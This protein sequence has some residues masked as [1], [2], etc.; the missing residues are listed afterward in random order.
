M[1][2]VL[3]KTFQSLYTVDFALRPSVNIYIYYTL[4]ILHPKNPNPRALDMAINLFQGVSV[5]V[6]FTYTGDS[7]ARLSKATY[8]QSPSVS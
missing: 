7:I 5:S 1:L 8:I 2:F 3:L 6:T 4:V